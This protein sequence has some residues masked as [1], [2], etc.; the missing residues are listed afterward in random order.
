MR[1]LLGAECAAT[2]STRTPK[3][4]TSS[5][6]STPP[7]SNLASRTACVVHRRALASLIKGVERARYSLL[8][9]LV[10]LYEMQTSPRRGGACAVY[11]A[12]PAYVL[13]VSACFLARVAGLR[14][15][16]RPIAHPLACLCAGSS[17]WISCTSSCRPR[18]SRESPAAAACLLSR[19][20]RC[21][22]PLP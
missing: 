12:H 10:C 6:S 11:F 20:S 8:T 7:V 22:S 15:L 4:S 19:L 14:Q 21:E 16:V 9:S 2:S 5:A 1:A 18:S 3:S 13:P 17:W